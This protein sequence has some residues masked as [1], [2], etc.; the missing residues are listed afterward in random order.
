MALSPRFQEALVLAAELH[1]DQRRK[2]TDIPYVSHLLAVAALVLE[3]GGTEDEA[4]AGLLHDAVEDQGGHATLNLIRERFGDTVAE[5]VDACS[6][7][8]VLPKPPWR[9]RK[10]DYIAA[11]PHHS[12]S[13]R[14]VSAAD[15]V[16]NAATIL[17]DYRAVG[18]ALWGRFTGRR[19]GT[20][21]YYRTLADTFAR[22]G[23][24][25]LADALGRVVAELESLTDG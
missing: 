20:M 21:W 15:K 16:H 11:L 7:A 10:E 9:Q 12:P 17:R 22:L 2:G 14:L 25:P 3:H 24:E 5:I 13:A 23:P 19:D 18:P 4:I 1:V 8:Y 6:D